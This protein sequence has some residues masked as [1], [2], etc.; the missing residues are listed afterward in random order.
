MWRGWWAS[1]QRQAKEEAPDTTNRGSPSQEP[2]P[3]I[4]TDY[5]IHIYLTAHSLLES[6]TDLSI[7]GGLPLPPHKGGRGSIVR[8]S[9]LSIYNGTKHRFSNIGTLYL[10]ERIKLEIC[11]E[12]LKQAFSQ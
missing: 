10:K 12:A 6:L 2:T 7:E 4:A 9:R 5:Y 11:K 8:F 3:I 1:I